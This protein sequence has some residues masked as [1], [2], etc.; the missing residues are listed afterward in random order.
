MVVVVVVGWSRFDCG[1]WIVVFCV[2]MVVLM[3]VEKWC[4]R[5]MVA[6]V[7]VQKRPRVR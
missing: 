7:E 4:L 3:V 5:S 6:P 2:V 1:L